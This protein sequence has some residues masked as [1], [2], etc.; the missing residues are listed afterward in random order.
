MGSDDSHGVDMEDVCKDIP[1][2][3]LEKTTLLSREEIEAVMNMYEE[4]K[5]TDKKKKNENNNNTTTTTTT[6]TTQSQDDIKS[7]IAELPMFLQTEALVLRRHEHQ[8]RQCMKELVELSECI[9]MVCDGT[10]RQYTPIAKHHILTSNTSTT[11]ATTSTSIASLQSMVENDALQ[12]M[13]RRAEELERCVRAAAVERVR[14][15]QRMVL[16]A[17]VAK[18]KNRAKRRSTA[19]VSGDGVKK[20]KIYKMSGRGKRE[21]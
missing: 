14:S 6:T 9:V 17:T 3:C 20:S 5:E 18:H 21:E 4:N 8:F 7:R 16:A 2:W 10:L 11:T 1:R 12:R 15:A 13:L 19:V